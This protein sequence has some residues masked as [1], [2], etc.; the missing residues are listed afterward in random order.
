MTYK[1]QI[2]MTHTVIESPLQIYTLR[3]KQFSY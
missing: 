2:G 1:I 3:K